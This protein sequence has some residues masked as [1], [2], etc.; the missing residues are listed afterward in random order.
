MNKFSTV[1]SSHRSIRHGAVLALLAVS[2]FGKNVAAAPEPKMP[3]RFDQATVTRLVRDIDKD[4]SAVVLKRGYFSNRSVQDYPVDK[5]LLLLKKTAEQEKKGSARWFLL[6]S[7][8]AYAGVRSSKAEE[9]ATATSLYGT[10]FTAYAQ[11]PSKQSVKVVQRSIY[12]F[13]NA[14]PTEK[15]DEQVF[16][17][18]AVDEAQ[19][20]TAFLQALKAYIVLLKKNKPYKIAMP[21]TEAVTHFRV[22]KEAS[23]LVEQAVAPKQGTVVS[24]SLYFLAAKILEPSSPIRA[25]QMRQKAEK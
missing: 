10:L 15:G 1:F 18:A 14:V 12:E 25:E 8:R 23:E 24:P 6:Q 2:F 3:S 7:V 9:R 20:K 17:S 16:A 11:S 13:L 22:G 4:F 5:G 19:G 21:W